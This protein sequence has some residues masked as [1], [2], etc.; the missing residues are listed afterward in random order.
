MT[1]LTGFGLAGH[2]T[3]MTEASGLTARI[4]LADMPVITGAT[5]LSAA[6]HRSSLDPANRAAVLGRAQVPDTPLGRLVF[7]PQTAGGFLA[8][9]PAGEADQIIAALRGAG[10][11]C[12]VIG[13]FAPGPARSEFC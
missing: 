7:D 10:Q 6:G 1:D 3:G 12:W 2:L 4:N 13:R 5:A 8:A 9:L 11:P